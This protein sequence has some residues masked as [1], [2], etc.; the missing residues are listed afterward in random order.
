MPLKTESIELLRS[1]QKLQKIREDLEYR[2]SMRSLELLPE[3]GVKLQ[4]LKGLDF[5]SATEVRHFLE[6]LYHCMI[7]RGRS[8]REEIP[9]GQQNRGVNIG[10]DRNTCP[11]RSDDV[12]C[13]SAGHVK[14]PLL[15]AC[16]LKAPSS[17]TSR[18][19]Q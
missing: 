17:S 8:S 11:W 3:Y 4:I 5:V 10:H 13:V 15:G 14:R 18:R 1:E 2:L 12:W 6:P 19:C 16:C 9:I 7:S